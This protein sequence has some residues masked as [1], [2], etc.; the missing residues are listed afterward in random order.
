M[1]LETRRFP[2]FYRL[3]LSIFLLSCVGLIV[4]NKL[5][6]L[7]PGEMVVVTPRNAN[8]PLKLVGELKERKER[9]W[10]EPERVKSDCELHVIEPVL[11]IKG[12]VVAKLIA[13]YGSW[14]DRAYELDFDVARV[15]ASSKEVRLSRNLP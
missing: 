9:Y 4:F 15:S 11:E 10:F 12:P 5:N 13:I 8:Q 3:L 2:I 14:R 7:R 1:H 6:S